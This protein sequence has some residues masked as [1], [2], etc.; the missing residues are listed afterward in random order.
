DLTRRKTLLGYDLLLR[1]I[2]VRR[3][4][5]N[6]LDVLVAADGTVRIALPDGIQRMQAPRNVMQRIASGGVAPIAPDLANRFS[7]R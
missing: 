5:S 6:C 1:E 2:T 7:P 4:V 3:D